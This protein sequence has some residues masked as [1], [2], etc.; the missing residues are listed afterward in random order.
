MVS[1]TNL[2]KWGRLL[3]G[4][5]VVTS[6]V[7]SF[8]A[9]DT[10]VVAKNLE[11]VL[12]L[13]PAEAY[14]NT[15]G[16]MLNNAYSRLVKRNPDKPSEVLGDVADRWEASSDGITFTFHIRQKQLFPDGREVTAD[17]AAYSLLRVVKLN[18]TPSFL[19]SQFGWTPANVSELIS[20][21]APDTLVLKLANPLAPGLVLQVL[22]TSP[23][24]LVDKEVVQRHEKDNDWGNG[25]LRTAW[26]GS[27]PFSIAAWR[28][29]EA[30]VLQANPTY[31]GDKPLLKRVIFRHVAESATQALLIAKGDVDV[32]YNLDPDQIR[33]L[34]PTDAFTL[35]KTQK[36]TEIYIPL[37]EKNPAL[38]N[39]KVRQALRWAIDY[40]GIAQNLLAGQWIVHQGLYGRGIEGASTDTPFRLDIAKAKAL[41]KE[42]GLEKGLELNMDVETGSP[43]PE[44]AQSIQ[45]TLAQ[46]GVTLNLLQSDRRQVMTKYRARAHELILW[47][48][49]VD[50]NDPNAGASDYALNTDNSDQASSKNRAWRSGW[51]NQKASELTRAA[52]REQDP[53]KRRALY[54][55]LQTL[56]WDEAPYIFAFQQVEQIVLRSSVR[57][58]QS[59]PNYDSASYIHVRKD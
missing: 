25:W 1:M 24:S 43:Y 53:L 54:A 58:F 57:G 49:S 16:E 13:D 26:A 46:A 4:T 29:K 51:V 56:V 19:F 41:L 6:S 3:I 59:G 45:S 36:L 48:A 21:P 55:Q 39:P 34:S 15:T 47:H 2:F 27:G 50:Y 10:L 11:D 37:N 9:S 52:Q 14:E 30:I 7:Y 32:A 44:I 38:A 12:T 35:T 40:Q 8:A 33:S 18:K 42:A 28:A 22:A 20:A 5:L 31:Y 17:D 23:G